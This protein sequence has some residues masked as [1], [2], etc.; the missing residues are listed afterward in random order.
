MEAFFILQN[1]LYSCIQNKY[2]DIYQNPI[3]VHSNSNER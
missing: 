1:I 3:E 2:D